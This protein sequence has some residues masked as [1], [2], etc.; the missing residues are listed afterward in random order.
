MGG[1]EKRKGA[2]A[3]T[4]TPHMFYFPA[5]ELAAAKRAKSFVTTARKK[6]EK[7]IYIRGSARAGPRCIIC[8]HIIV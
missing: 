1:G 5:H 6:K 2:R 3:D 7:K 8:T 4:L